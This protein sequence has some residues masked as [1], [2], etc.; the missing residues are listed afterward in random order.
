[1]LKNYS[2]LKGIV[3]QDL[4]DH[5]KH[6]MTHHNLIVQAN[7]LDY[8]VNI[9]TQSDSIPNVKVY[10]TDQFSNELLTNLDKLG[11]EG[12][13]SLD[14]LPYT[15]RLD[16]LR[17]E[18]LKVADLKNMLPKSWQEISALLDQYLICGTK[19]CILGASYY[20]S[21]TRQKMPYGLHLR[22]T[23]NHLPP[24][25]IHDI[26]MNQGA[27]LMMPQSANNG[28]YQDG[29]IFVETP[30]NANKA[31]FFKFM[32]QSLVTDDDGNPLD[33]QGKSKAWADE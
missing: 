27:S 14:K 28:I 2:C 17:S 32:G 8:Q 22:Q 15:S 23:Y 6:T 7:G 11:N 33:E 19:V 5:I 30:N 21:E 16:Y 26:H 9:D 25:G 13:F 3:S 29:A 4:E 1:M 31:F 12:L 20:D 24:R 10:Y 18:I